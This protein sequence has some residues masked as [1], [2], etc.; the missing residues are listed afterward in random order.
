MTIETKTGAVLSAAALAYIFPLV[1]LLT[2]LAVSAAAGAPEMIVV[3]TGVASFVLGCA[4]SVLIN[5]RLR[6]DAPL[7][8][9]VISVSR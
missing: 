6:K 1:F 2:A 9:T 8:Y 5:K 4:V 3:I 7:E